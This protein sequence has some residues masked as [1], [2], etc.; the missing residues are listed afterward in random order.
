MRSIRSHNC[1]RYFYFDWEVFW[2]VNS[3]LLVQW[4]IWDVPCYLG[5]VIVQCGTTRRC[6]CLTGCGMRRLPSCRIQ[7]RR[8]TRTLSWCSRRGRWLLARSH[9]SCAVS[10]Q[11]PGTTGPDTHTH[12][13]IWGK[14]TCSLTLRSHF[15]VT[16]QWWFSQFFF[17]SMRWALMLW[18]WAW[19][20]FV[21]F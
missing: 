21:G 10:H 19:P 2:D 9:T 7:K 15:E 1:V 16:S 8:H 14:Q 20:D 4:C 12:S 3:Y 17:M 11:T 18:L 6:V 5:C 13:Y